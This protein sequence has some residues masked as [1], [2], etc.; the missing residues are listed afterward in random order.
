MYLVIDKCAM[1]MKLQVLL[2]ST[3]TE[4]GD[5]HNIIKPQSR[6]HSGKE[7]KLGWDESQSK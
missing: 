6:H 5:H 2:S 4:D 7:Q 3:Q 1:E